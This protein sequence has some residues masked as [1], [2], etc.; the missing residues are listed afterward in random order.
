[1]VE[2]LN[3]NRFISEERNAI[4][5]I[6][7]ARPVDSNQIVRLIQ[8]LATNMEETSPI[9]VSYVCQSLNCLGFGILLAEEAGQVVG[10]LSYSIRPSL[11]HAANSGL[12][13]DLVVDKASRGQSVGSALL[14]EFMSQMQARGC[15]EVSVTTMPDNIGALRFYKAHGL[16]DESVFLEKHF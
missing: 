14:E 15:A 1:M 4:M 7:E 2:Q 5:L 13:E 8:E 16:V 10:L 9:T 11:F 3:K 6:R 12:I